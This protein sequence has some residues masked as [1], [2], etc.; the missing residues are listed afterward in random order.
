MKKVLLIGLVCV[1]ALTGVALA[2]KCPMMHK[3]HMKGGME[4]CCPMHH[5]MLKAMMDRKLVPTSDGGAILLHGVTLTK[6]GSDL[7]VQKEVEVKCNPEAMKKAMDDMR[8]SCP[9]CK[10]GGKC[11]REEMEE[12]GK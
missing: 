8:A 5:A 1:T 7:S 3:G 6:Y 12:H 11:G 9:M 10:K 2:M 4:S